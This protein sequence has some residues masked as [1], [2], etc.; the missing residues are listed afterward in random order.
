MGPYYDHQVGRLIP[1]DSP[2]PVELYL[3][4]GRRAH[5]RAMGDMLK[6]LVVWLSKMTRQLV[7]VA[8]A[9]AMASSDQEC[10]GRSAAA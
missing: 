2:D 10:R 7:G 9:P 8:N 3:Q 6:H 1:P 5:A 4:R